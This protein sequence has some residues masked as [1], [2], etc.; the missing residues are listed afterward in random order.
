MT[1]SDELA[2]EA[3]DIWQADRR[4]RLALN[5]LAHRP[6]EFAAPGDLDP[7]LDG[8]AR[9]IAAGL[10]RNL[11]LTGGVGAGKTWSAWKAAETA[12]RA[13]YEGGVTVTTAARLRRVCAPATADP[14]ELARY[15]TAGLL[16]LDD[17]G[18]FRLSEWDLDHLGELTDE[19]WAEHRPTALTSNKTDIRAL[20]GP[21]I[22][23][24]LQHN[25]LVIELDGP[26]RR[27]QQP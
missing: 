27:R 22:S 13:G 14:A 24:R 25:A 5:L 2:G 8:W 26:D 12:V 20:L 23:S 21:R 6:A 9:Q 16:I 7:D 3:L 17:L 11:V 18:A 4:E 15:T 1:T 10:F 19:R